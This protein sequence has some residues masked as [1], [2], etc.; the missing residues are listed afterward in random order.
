MDEA[1][2]VITGRALVAAARDAIENGMEVA[3]SARGIGRWKVMK[4]VDFTDAYA[5]ADQEP[6]LVEM[7]G[8]YGNVK[9]AVFLIYEADI[10]A[11]RTRSKVAGAVRI[12]DF[13]PENPFNEA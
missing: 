5:T 7:I 9:D 12:D 2:R 1:Q 3:V 8:A 11:I 10:R 6:G 4:S 13:D